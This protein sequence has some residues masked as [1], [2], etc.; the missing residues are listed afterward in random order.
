MIFQFAGLKIV[1]TPAAIGLILCIVGATSASDPDDIESQATVKA[2]IILFLAVFVLLS[3][4]T[5]VAVLC[6]SKLP[7]QEKKLI[8]AVGAAL[9]LILLRIIY[10]L[11]AAFSHKPAFN[12]VTGSKTIAL[13]MD[14]FPEMLVVVLYVA[15]GLKVKDTPL[16]EGASSGRKIGYR[17]GRG[18]FGTGKLGILSVIFAI[19]NACSGSNDAQDDEEMGR[20]KPDG[21]HRDQSLTR[22][23]PYTASPQ[24]R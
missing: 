2:G 1:Q 12:F 15:V 5:L 9:P 6:R 8:Y 17:L 21:R 22:P 13:F 24:R 11:L 19:L 23:P 7:E 18:D 20:G 3:I 16:E 4:L 10:S 14:D